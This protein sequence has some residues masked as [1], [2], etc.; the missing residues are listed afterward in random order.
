MSN[1]YILIYPDT[2]VLTSNMGKVNQT[3]K[4]LQP[5]GIDVAIHKDGAYKFS[6]PL[7]KL[8]DFYVKHKTV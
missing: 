2:T 8:V 3:S 4:I 7:H 1:P 6:V 5:E